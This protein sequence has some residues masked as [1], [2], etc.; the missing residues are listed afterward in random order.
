M[1]GAN[2]SKTYEKMFSLIS[3]VEHANS[4]HSARAFHTH[5]TGR[6]LESWIAASQGSGVQG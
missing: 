4:N 1:V 2:G 3:S 6:L 5:Q